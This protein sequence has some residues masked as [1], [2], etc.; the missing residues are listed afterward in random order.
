MRCLDRID[1]AAARA[2]AKGVVLEVRLEDRLQHDLGGGLNHP[3]P[4]RRDAEGTFATP[5][6]RDRR[7][8]HRIGPVRLRHEFLAQAPTPDASICSK[9]IRSTPGAPALARE[10]A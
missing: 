9:V 5:R 3:V 8:P 2:I 1:R 10:S 4:N 6:L 7:P